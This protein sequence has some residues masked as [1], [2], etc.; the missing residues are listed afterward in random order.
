[1]L[2]DYSDDMGVIRAINDNSFDDLDLVGTRTWKKICQIRGQNY[3]QVDPEV[4]QSLCTRR[5]YAL[6]R[7]NPKGF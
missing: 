7:R 4:W 1:M 6:H 5:G 3:S 2:V